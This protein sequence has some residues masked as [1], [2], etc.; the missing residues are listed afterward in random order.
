ML[1]Q[2]NER[3]SIPLDISPPSSW[4]K[5]PLVLGSHTDW[6]EIVKHNFYSPT[7]HKKL[8]ARAKNLLETLF[9][10]VFQLRLKRYYLH[11]VCLCLQY[12]ILFWVS[13]RN[14]NQNLAM[15]S[16]IQTHF[17]LITINSNFSIRNSNSHHICIFWC[18]QHPLARI[19]LSYCPCNLAITTRREFCIHK[20]R[21][22]LLSVTC[23][24]LTNKEA[25]STFS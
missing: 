19:I 10:L 7:T 16:Y 22:F 25:Q 18:L 11:S 1:N 24:M 6:Q 21:F 17:T 4:K 13:P 23:T 8:E 3:Q 15:H 14:S 12:C 2:E 5:I 9:C 20:L